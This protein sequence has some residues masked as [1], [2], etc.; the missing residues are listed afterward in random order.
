MEELLIVLAVIGVAGYFVYQFILENPDTTRLL[1]L[2]AAGMVGLYALVRLMMFAIRQTHRRQIRRRQR[3]QDAKRARDDALRQVLSLAKRY[4]G[5]LTAAQLHAESYLGLEESRYW[6]EHARNLG[7]AY[8]EPGERGVLIYVFPGLFPQR[9]EQATYDDNAKTRIY[10][11]VQQ[12]KGRTSERVHHKAVSVSKTIFEFLPRVHGVV[13]SDFELFTI[14][15]VALDYFPTLLEN[16]LQLAPSYAQNQP[17]EGNKTAEAV[18]EA[19][20]DLLH[21]STREMLENV[22]QQDAQ[23][24]L[25]TARFLE[26]RFNRSDLTLER[27]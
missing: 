1:A 4:G 6:L 25:K 20:L 5:T 14:K 3:Q 21:K 12:L 22:H 13:S 2:S 24:L 9:L 11:L 16:Y 10:N 7:E 26:D 18:L 17:I 23:A 19:R 27:D 15:Q 8:T